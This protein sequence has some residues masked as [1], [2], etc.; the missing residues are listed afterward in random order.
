MSQSK[1]QSNTVIAL[2]AIAGFSAAAQTGL[3]SQLF[4]VLEEGIIPSAQ[5]QTR[6]N[7]RPPTRANFKL[8]KFDAKRIIVEGDR[9]SFQ[10]E[11]G[12]LQPAAD[13]FYQ[14]PNRQ[15]L[16]VKD[17]RVVDHK[18]SSSCSGGQA[19]CRPTPRWGEWLRDTSNDSPR[20][21]IRHNGNVIDTWNK[22]QPT[23]LRN[24]SP[25]NIP[26]RDIRR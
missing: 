11:T 8:E 26:T 18:L 5:A 22:I 6:L 25:S 19:D 2:I 7:Q 15:T 10:S 24:V 20:N 21:Q 13:G 9:V 4:N 23:N 1:Q 14:L 16:T 12:K 3:V 17:G